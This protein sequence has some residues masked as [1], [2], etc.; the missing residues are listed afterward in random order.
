MSQAVTPEKREEIAR[1]VTCAIKRLAH[2][3]DSTEQDERLIAG[4]LKGLHIEATVTCGMVYFA[5]IKNSPPVSIN[6]MA[7]MLWKQLGLDG[8]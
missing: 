7:R 1:A 5:D 4:I 6:T 8:L 2:S 3:S